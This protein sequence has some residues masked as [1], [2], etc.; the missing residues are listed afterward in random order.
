M[1]T[2]DKTLFFPKNTEKNVLVSDWEKEYSLS[3]DMKDVQRLIRMDSS[4]KITKSE[5][6]NGAIKLEGENHFNVLYHSSEDD[7]IHSATFSDPFSISVDVNESSGEIFPF[8]TVFCSSLNC[9]VLSQRKIYIKSKNQISLS[10]KENVPVSV[11]D[12][13][14][15]NDILFFNTDTVPMQSFS[16]PTFKSFDLEETL[17]IDGTY[18]PIENV[19]FT[20]IKLL[21]LDVVKNISSAT[22]NTTAIF[23]VFYENS[24]NYYMFS[25][26]VPV[27]LTVEDE[28]IDENTLVYYF[29]TVTDKS[30]R[31][32]MDNY[33]EDRIIV[34][35]Y[36][37]ELFLFKIKETVEEIPND[38]FSPSDILSGNIKTV[39]YDELSGIIQ[40]PFTLEK[41]FELPEVEF[42]E[43]Y[44]TSAVMDVESTENTENGFTLNGRSGISVLGKTDRGIDTV[45][46]NVN[47]SQS[48]PEI[49]STLNNECTVI[50]VQSSATITGRN[51]ITV[52]VSANASIMQYERKSHTLLSD[53]SVL[54][55]RNIRE[56][57]CITIYYP[58]KTETLWD[59]SK[60]YGVDPKEIANENKSSF[61]ANGELDKNVKAVF[62]P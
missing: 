49:N 11:P 60:L 32:E 16:T 42:S 20:S 33:G 55:Q 34:F 47:F 53:Y 24:G 27:S 59:I 19:I 9:K 45:S 29:L 35:S 14:V 28:G 10:V 21:P 41:V 37:P 4:P 18:P 39:S 57:D 2:R 5:L 38:V 56:K 40:R 12:V 23:K 22:L 3:D 51:M 6:V 46:F 43:I 26:S 30:V 1:N 8:A 17:V 36:M 48:F 15:S 52:R 58:S 7:K 25:R 54:S 50:P 61:N 44:D 62:I 13:N 31:V